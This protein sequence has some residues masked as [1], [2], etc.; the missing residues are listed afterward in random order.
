MAVRIYSLA[1]ELA[2]DSKELVDICTRA[3]VTGKGSALASL[4]DDEVAK[5]KDFLSNKPSGAAPS[6]GGGG[7][8][9]KAPPAMERP[10]RPDSKTGRMRVIVPKK[11]DPKPP[12]DPAP[13]APAET[14]DAAVAADASEPPATPAPAEAPQPTPAGEAAEAKPTEP[15]SSEAKPAGEDAGGSEA[16]ESSTEERSDLSRPGPLAGMVRREDYMTPGGGSGRMPVVGGGGG[17]GGQG[18]KTPRKQGDAPKP[19]PVVKLAAMPTAAPA[20][21]KKTAKEEGG[22]AQKPDMKLPAEV[23]TGGKIGAKPLAAHLKR[24]ERTLEAEKIRSRTDET[25][26]RGRGT[27]AGGAAARDPNKPMLGG[28]E[29][30]Q[31]SRNRSGGS[32]RMPRRSFRTRR[33]RTGINTAAPRKG[34]ITVQLPCTVKELSESAGVPAAQIL[35]ILMAEGVMTTITAQIDPELTEFIA[36]ELDLDVDFAQPE[37]L[38]DRVLT[39]LEDRE[40]PAE[41]LVARAPVI[42]FLGHVDH[43][44]TSLLDKLIGIDVA[45]GESGGITQHIRAYQIDKDN[46][47]I[48]F[49]DTPGHAAFTEMRAR[50]A[51]VTDIAVIVVA[52]DDGVMPQT[53]EAISHA[54]AAD[55]PIVVALNKCDLPGVDINRAMQGLAAND[56]LPS[57]W[58]GEVEVI[59]T[60]AMTGEGLD[61]LL[62]TLLTVAELHEYTANPNRPAIGACLESQQDSDRGVVTKVMVTNGTLRV[63]DIIVCGDAYGR[64]KAMYDPLDPKKRLTEALPST[65]VNLTGL[66]T[67]PGAGERMYV[68]DDISQAREIAEARAHAERSDFLGATGYQQVTL[69]NLFDRLEGA[70]EVQTLNLII[71]ADVRGSIEAIEKELEKLDHPEVRL[72]ILQKGV[73]GITEGDIVLAEASD[74]I[75]IAFNV[76]PDDKARARASEVGVQIRRYG[77]IYKIT[78]ELRSAMEGMLKPEQREVEL[79]RVLVQL[80]FKISRIG[81]IAG[82]RVLQGVVS[83]DARVRVIRDNTIIGDYAVDT[84]RREKDDAKEVREGYECGIKLAG[85]NDIKEG[86]LFEAYKIEEIGRSFDD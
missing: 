35:R 33:K 67:A 20:A 13:E 16:A 7:S 82:C 51:N 76:V 58:G 38:E 66:D 46:K 31:L 8:T 18:A 65:P 62:D 25:G 44:K 79:G 61:D 4:S 81:S 40:D 39:A 78:D 53:E 54:K 22:P 52:A 10:S 74:A 24:A 59:K 43:G 14:P 19:R 1:K 15:Q 63:G 47:P 26:G 34:R 49:V 55:V 42:T 86:D 9:P 17:G 37:T 48:A 84:L 45:G 83:R 72:R 85:F 70:E 68:L 69:E 64:V 75:V 57:E 77:V 29:Q 30:R 2:V 21:P 56:L 73:G 6:G 32:S 12:A 23:L 80:V 60:S 36:A 71:R 41:D 28:R 27:A 50:G 11:A 5:V 3:G